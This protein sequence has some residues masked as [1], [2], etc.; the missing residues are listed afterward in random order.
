MAIQRLARRDRL[1]IRKSDMTFFPPEVFANVIDFL[2]IRP[3]PKHCMDTVPELKEMCR[4]RGLR[5]CGNKLDL[6]NRL[7]ESG[8]YARRAFWDTAEHAELWG[9]DAACPHPM[10]TFREVLHTRENWDSYS[11]R[12]FAE[13]DSSC[14]GTEYDTRTHNVTHPLP[15]GWAMIPD[16]LGGVLIYCRRGSDGRVV[17][18]QCRRPLIPHGQM[19]PACA[20]SFQ[21][22]LD[23]HLGPCREAATKYNRYRGR[24]CSGSKR[25]RWETPDQYSAVRTSV[26]APFDR[27]GYAR[28]MCHGQPREEALA[29]R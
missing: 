4:V 29:L 7:L 24:M 28:L 21:A 1:P 27:L 13:L 19:R 14:P 2:R 12:V 16:A 15:A 5:V 23:A 11:K 9:A 18:A 25:W 17:A 10:L 20:D 3:N 26:I 22:C 8:C 6:I